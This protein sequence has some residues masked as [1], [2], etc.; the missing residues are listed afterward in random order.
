MTCSVFYAIVSFIALPWVT[1]LSLPGRI[2][3]PEKPPLLTRRVENVAIRS[4][5]LQ[6]ALSEIAQRYEIPIGVELA[7]NE[8]L[9][10]S[11][12]L[13]DGTVEQ[14]LNM[15]MEDAPRYQ[16]KLIDGV[17]LVSARDMPDSVLEDILNTSISEFRVEPGVNRLT[18]RYSIVKLPEVQAKLDLARVQ[19][20]I[21]STSSY[22]LR[23]LDGDFPL[24][25]RK[26][27]LRNILNQI[28][29]QSEAKLW[30]IGRTGRS[31][32]F[33]VLGI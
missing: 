12:H 16:W 15:V 19:P 30:F 29:L 9:R 24:H 4:Q 6:F 31:D 18:L 20:F 10:V 21:G 5:P 8:D 11:V 7:Q 22:D 33:L 1:S 3:D 28:V 23:R 13:S 14:V 26:S 27:S 2:T 17:V 32:E 25:V